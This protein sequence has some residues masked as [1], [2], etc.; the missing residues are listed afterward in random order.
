MKHTENFPWLMLNTNKD[1]ETFDK[2]LNVGAVRYSTNHICG[3]RSNFQIGVDGNAVKVTV[4]SENLCL[5]S[6]LAYK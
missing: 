3:L 2:N 5:N 6:A 4:L 1:S